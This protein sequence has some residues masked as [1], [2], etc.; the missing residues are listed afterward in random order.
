[1][2]LDERVRKLEFGVYPVMNK[3]ICRLAMFVLVFGPLVAAQNQ[4]SAAAKEDPGPVGRRVDYLLNYLNMAG[5][6]KGSDFR[7][8]TQREGT[9]RRPHD[10]VKFSHPASAV[11]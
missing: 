9:S 2:R 4:N 6:N 7:P 1:M 10:Y 5:T 11:I 8:L 3:S